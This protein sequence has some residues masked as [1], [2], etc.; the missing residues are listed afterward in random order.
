LVCVAAGF[1]LSL[2][3]VP[4]KKGQEKKKRKE[5]VRKKYAHSFLQECSDDSGIP[6]NRRV[7]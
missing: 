7:A 6:E 5:N 2:P 1:N 3:F 4:K